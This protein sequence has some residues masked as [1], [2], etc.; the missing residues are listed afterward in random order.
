MRILALPAALL[1]AACIYLPFPRLVEI[2]AAALRGLYA[3]FLR[4]FI[5]KNGHEDQE[6]AL[7]LFMLIIGGL[8]QLA[9]GLHIIAAGA[10]IA[11]ALTTFSQMPQAAS[12]KDQLDRGVY[13]RSFGE[14]DA[15]VRTAC[16]AL[17]ASFVTDM[18]APLLLA[19]LGTPLHLGCA[20]SGAY[21]TAR[22]L[23][24]HNPAARRVV[25]IVG[26]PAWQVMRVLMLLCSGLTGRSP[27]QV[28]GEDARTLMLSI[29]GI[30]GDADETH[31]PVSGDIAQAIFIGLFAIA[32]LTLMLCLAL[33]A[34]CR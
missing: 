15:R 33:Y 14:Y 31:T 4:L 25:R 9:G 7:V 11:P 19:A 5:R 32:L 12:I 24:E 3:R 23:T 20:L 27:F 30:T 26:L 2:I 34:I 8:C 18:C 16:A 21:F 29:I 22:T 10:L 1:I 6:I 28:H 13:A 17:G